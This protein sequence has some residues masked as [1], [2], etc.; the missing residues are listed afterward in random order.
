MLPLE[1]Q[2]CDLE[3]SKKLQEL[4]VKQESLFCWSVDSPVSMT[5]CVVRTEYASSI[6]GKGVE[7]SAFTV[8]ELGDMLP[9]HI[10]TQQEDWGW[11]LYVKGMLRPEFNAETEANARASMLCYLLENRLIPAV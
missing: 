5:P 2:V 4:E 9:D 11:A 8:A 6:H 10:G 3:Y 7:C 1:K